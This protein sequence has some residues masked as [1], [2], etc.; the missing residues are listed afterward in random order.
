MIQVKLQKM[1]NGQY[2][3]TVPKPYVDMK[4]WKKTQK[5]NW[6]VVKGKLMLEEVKNEMVL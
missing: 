5:L 4:E 1:K 6:K 3:I 2:L